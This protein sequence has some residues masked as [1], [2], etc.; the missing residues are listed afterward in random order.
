MKSLRGETRLCRVKRTDLI[1]P[2]TKCSISPEGK[3]RRFHRAKRHDFTFVLLHFLSIARRLYIISHS[4]WAVAEATLSGD[5]ELARQ[6]DIKINACL[7]KYKEISDVTGIPMDY[8]RLASVQV[9]TAAKSA[10]KNTHKALTFNPEADFS[11]KLN[12]LSAIANDGISKAARKVAE[13]GGTTKTEHLSVVNLSTGKEE[14]YEIGDYGSVGGD[15]FWKFISDNSDKELAFI[16][17]HNTDGFLSETDMWT[18]LSNKC[19]K[20]MG[21]V[22]IDGVK[23][24]AEK[25]KELP[26]VYYYDKLFENELK[27]LNN[28]VKNGII[29]M[30]ERTHK[31]EEIIVDLLLKR[32]T[33][34][35]VEIDGR[36]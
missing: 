30:A 18:L 6:C 26:G 19:I 11:V 2:N 21:A 28:E 3:A 9:K 25:T 12:S 36:K 16:H 8:K 1:S 23:Y 27:G 34:G 35:L 31:R 32:Y 20:V 14:Y 4:P 5:N 22:R 29:T 7:K 15:K 13:L 17:N 24:F 33:K 10:L